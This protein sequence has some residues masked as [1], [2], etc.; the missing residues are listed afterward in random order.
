MLLAGVILIAGVALTWSRCSHERPENETAGSRTN[1]HASEAGLEKEESPPPDSLSSKQPREQETEAA[2]RVREK[3]DSIIIPNIDFDD[4]S[5]EEAIDFLRIRAAELDP[6]PDSLPHDAIKLPES[7]SNGDIG[8]R[9]ILTFSEKNISM[10][11]VLKRIAS[12]C[13]MKIKSTDE[14]IEL[15]PISP[16][17]G[18]AK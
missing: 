2:R 3:L 8:A 5:F 17:P 16:A 9:R 1:R 18:E 11:K 7:T 14:G 6:H 13:R 4:T 15:I 12:D 10:W